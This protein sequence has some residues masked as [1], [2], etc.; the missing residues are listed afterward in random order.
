ML[1]D[2]EK[3]F[4]YHPPQPGQPEKYVEI[5][6]TAKKFAELLNTLCPDSREK[7]LAVTHIEEA[8]FWANA[9]IARNGEGSQRETLVEQ[10]RQGIEAGIATSIK[11]RQGG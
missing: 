3:R 9:S 6:E 2:L 1:T 8:V 4:T 7:S 5:R 11:V 10:I